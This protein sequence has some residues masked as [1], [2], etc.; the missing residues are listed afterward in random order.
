MVRR[1]GRLAAY[2]LVGTALWTLAVLAVPMGTA[3]AYR[4][5]QNADARSIF[6]PAYWATQAAQTPLYHREMIKVF[7]SLEGWHREQFPTLLSWPMVRT[8]VWA[9]GLN[10]GQWRFTR[11][12]RVGSDVNL[13]SLARQVAPIALGGLAWPWLS[14]AVLLSMRASL[15]KARIDAVAVARAVV[16]ANDV[17]V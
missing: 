14:A 6:G 9:Y 4:A 16:Y 5:V 2:W 15:R 10:P 1:P 7:G 8:V 17:T 11:Y 13:I 12:G 3:M